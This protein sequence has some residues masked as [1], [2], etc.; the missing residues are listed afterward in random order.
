M[1]RGSACMTCFVSS[2]QATV[3]IRRLLVDAVDFSA[4]GVFGVRSSK[5]YC[6]ACLALGCH[7]LVPAMNPL[8]AY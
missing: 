5:R 1:K 8:Y 6:G 7:L 3:L 4:C 2:P